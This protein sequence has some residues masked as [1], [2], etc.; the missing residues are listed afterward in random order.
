MARYAY[1]SLG[2]TSSRGSS[3]PPPYSQKASAPPAYPGASR[4]SESTP[5]FWREEVRI[6]RD[7]RTTRRTYTRRTLRTGDR[8]IGISGLSDS[9]STRASLCPLCLIAMG[10]AAL[11]VFLIIILMNLHWTSSVQWPDT[12]TYSVAIVGKCPVLLPRKKRGKGD[13]NRTTHNN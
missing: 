6:T 1:S 4:A 10:L 5:L 13:E 3:P 2:S 11:M 8:G 12:P 9:L 7:T